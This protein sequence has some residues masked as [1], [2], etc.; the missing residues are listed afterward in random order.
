MK[1]IDL[2]G[3]KFNRFLVE[4]FVE[5]R[6][7]RKFYRVLCD[8]GNRRTVS[9]TH[10]TRK[11]RPSKSCGCFLREWNH[12]TKR[13]HGFRESSFYYFWTRLKNR[14]TLTKKWNKF[15]SF[16]KDMFSEYIENKI[17]KNVFFQ[18]K[19]YRK[20]FSKTNYYWAKQ[21]HCKKITYSI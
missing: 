18:K 17:G 4:E 19:D 21:A 5:V 16:K 20:P 13:K 8:C 2:R 15:I 7:G 1:I 11:N 6:N 14:H 10:L 9:G 3:L 12:K